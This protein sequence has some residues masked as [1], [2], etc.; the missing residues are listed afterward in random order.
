[1]AIT[2]TPKPSRINTGKDCRRD[3]VRSGA[4]GFGLLQIR[5]KSSTRQP[6]AGNATANTLQEQLHRVVCFR[7]S[8]HLRVPITL[9]VCSSIVTRTTPF[10]VSLVSP[11]LAG[12][13]VSAYRSPLAAVVAPPEFL[14]ERA[15]K[16][17]KQ[18]RA[19]K[20]EPT[21]YLFGSGNSVAFANEARRCRAHLR[22]RHSI[23]ASI[24]Q[25]VNESRRE[26]EC[27]QHRQ[28]CGCS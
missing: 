26:S 19:P 22:I 14:F 18:A 17:Q 4:G 9:P 28:P 5:S 11:I 3:A 16:K 27:E 6:P 13:Q 7:C 1:M 21:A 23:H 15:R 2:A 8:E 12:K 24:E 20:P 25:V 10:P